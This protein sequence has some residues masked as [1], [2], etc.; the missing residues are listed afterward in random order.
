MNTKLIRTLFVSLMSII[1]ISPIVVK[2][3][4]I[5]N[6]SEVILIN[7][8]QPLSY[9]GTTSSNSTWLRPNQGSN[10]TLSNVKP[11][12]HIQ[13]FKVDT[14]GNYNIISKQNYDGYIH[15]YKGDFDLTNPCRYYLN[16][17]DDGQGGITTS[18]LLNQPLTADTLYVLITSGFSAIDTG[19]FTNTITGP[20]NITLASA[21]DLQVTQS[22]NGPVSVNQELIYT[23]QVTNNGPEPAKNVILINNLPAKS[24]FISA[25]DTCATSENQLVCSLNTLEVNQTV[26][27]NLVIKPTVGGTTLF[28]EVR[29]TADTTDFYSSNNQSS[30]FVSIVDNDLLP[31][32]DIVFIFDESGSMGDEIM[33]I[34][35][36]L[37]DIVAQLRVSLDYR[38][39]LV[40][41]GASN[42]ANQE[43]HIHLTLTDD[44]DTFAAALDELVAYGG[45]EPAF[46][47]VVLSLSDQ[48]GFRDRAGVCTILITDE[49]A[50]VGEH[51][52]AD[53]LTALTNR[54]AVFL[55]IVNPT[56]K[57][58]YFVE[59]NFSITP[60]KTDAQFG[61][62][63]GSLAA[64]TDGQVFDIRD[65]R[66]N[67]QPVLTA[68]IQK[69]VGEIINRQ[70]VIRGQAWHDANQNGVQETL[71]DGL[72]NVTVRLFKANSQ[73]ATT[74]TDGQGNYEFSNLEAGSYYL[75][76]DL[77]PGYI[78]SPPNQGTD[79][80]IDSDADPTTGRT[81][82][83]NLGTNQEARHWDAGLH[84]ID[85]PT[86]SLRVQTF[87][88]L[89]G[90]T[91]AEPTEPGLNGW[92]IRVSD[93]QATDIISLTTTQ[94]NEAGWV[95]FDNL[96]PGNYTVCETLPAGWQASLAPCQET[97]VTAEVETSLKFGNYQPA[98]ITV[99]KEANLTTD[100][101]FQFTTTNLTPTFELAAGDRLTF[102]N[103]KPD[104]YAISET[105]P[106]G[107]QLISA[108]CDNGDPVTAITLLSGEAITC[109]MTNEA[110]PAS[111][112][113]VKQVVGLV[114]N[115]DWGFNIT[116]PTTIGEFTLPAAGGET[117]FNNLTAGEY[118]LT[119][120]SVPG[121]SQTVSCDNGDIGNSRL[122]LTLQPGQEVT[123]RGINTANDGQARLTLI[124]Q[125]DQAG[126]FEFTSNI[127]GLANFTLS[128]GQAT[129]EVTILPGSYTVA[130]VV[131]HSPSQDEAPWTLL[132]VTCQDQTGTTYSAN[133]PAT[134]GV[135]IT[136]DSD[137]FTAMLTIPADKTLSCTFVNEKADLEVPKPTSY[138]RFLP[139]I[140]K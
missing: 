81:G 35:T 3:T 17:D 64:E 8:I 120:T 100:A 26:N 34:K 111:L 91:Q 129:D 21:A 37:N 110:E 41:F 33:E 69:C 128:N 125:A 101:L 12:Y 6:E 106:A 65:F 11:N 116:G 72:A 44:D 134:D 55:G 79:E 32:G 136:L 95:S 59:P 119:E 137:A 90:N 123:C 46:D 2:A 15:L 51:N 61:P 62:E 127:P 99:I 57:Q 67:S 68:I 78:F 121:Y 83:I 94:N 4:G 74:T 18:E 52:Q 50:D 43:A 105:V 135:A 45:F 76:F 20:G 73:L 89:N 48:M 132:T 87:H 107:W 93:G 27:L 1:L 115:D 126:D 53:A 133:T 98:Q 13:T 71:E 138:L 28:N 131:T 88:D 112:T 96:L 10:C 22:H 122:N 49:D 56:S 70:G 25:S 19:S 60:N 14:T 82:T 16:G 108:G 103:L 92:Q 109:T 31:L 124:K 66:Q 80:T 139:L 75:K 77:R 118:T 130:E 24:T 39:G 29:V 97:V 63:A 86:G 84:L 104:N 113:I 140:V 54:Q 114:P 58:A 36:R 9:S 23:F 38:L 5:S 7:Q 30:S 42:H 40:G 47:A 117:T 85:A 102:E